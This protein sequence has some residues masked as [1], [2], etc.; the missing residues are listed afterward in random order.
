MAVTVS[1]GEVRAM[2]TAPR[3]ADSGRSTDVITYQIAESFLKRSHT[4]GFV[5]DKETVNFSK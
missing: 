2:N 5:Y 3:D 4:L 1:A